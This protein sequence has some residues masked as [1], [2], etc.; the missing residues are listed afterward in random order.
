MQCSRLKTALLAGLFAL[1]GGLL[2]GSLVVIY[3]ATQ[4]KKVQQE[5]RAELAHESNRG[6]EIITSAI[7]KLISLKDLKELKKLTERERV[8]SKE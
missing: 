1:V 7:S 3:L 5:I 4:L 8:N 2:G 6:R